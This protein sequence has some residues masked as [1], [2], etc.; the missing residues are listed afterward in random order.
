MSACRQGSTENVEEP[1]RQVAVRLIAGDSRLLQVCRA[2]T[3]VTNTTPPLYSFGK[4]PNA[5]SKKSSLMHD[6]RG[7]LRGL[8]RV[9]QPEVCVSIYMC[10]YIAI[11][12]VG[13]S[14]FPARVCHSLCTALVLRVCDRDGLET[15][16]GVLEH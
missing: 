2:H 9:P 7:T 3:E 6:S 5:P 14:P 11:P 16:P 1:D 4:H 15:S 8:C 10:A 12:L 13:I